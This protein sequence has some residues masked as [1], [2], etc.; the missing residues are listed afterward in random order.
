M[1]ISEKEVANK[2]TELINKLVYDLQ[3]DDQKWKDQYEE[4]MEELETEIRIAK[5]VILDFNEENLTLN[6][7]EQ[8]GYLRCLITMVNRFKD[9]ER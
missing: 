2:L 4:V 5:E 7:I 9:W 1:K 6:K 3:H 8:E